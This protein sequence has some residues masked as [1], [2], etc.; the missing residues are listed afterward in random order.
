MNPSKRQVTCQECKEKTDADEAVC[1][2]C[3]EDI[4]NIAYDNGFN[5]G[6]TEGKKEGYDSGHDEGYNEG[7]SE[8]IKQVQKAIEKL[9]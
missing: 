5:D 3:F 2:S 4:Q 8:A 6:K 7:Y 9:S 1:Q